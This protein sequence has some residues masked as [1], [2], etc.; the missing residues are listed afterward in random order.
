MNVFNNWIGVNEV[1]H[2]FIYYLLRKNSKSGKSSNLSRFFSEFQ[3]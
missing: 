3:Y 2:L 1:E